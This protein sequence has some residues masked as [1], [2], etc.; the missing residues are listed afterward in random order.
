M[1]WV[2][3]E[4]VPI[5]ST[6][7]L[8]WPK[9]AYLGGPGP[10]DDPQRGVIWTSPGPYLDPRWEVVWVQDGDPPALGDH[11]WK[12]MLTTNPH[13]IWRPNNGPVPNMA[14]L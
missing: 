5:S 3:L 6:C 7:A 12:P 2:D 13:S 11:K 14:P 9:L 4:V 8:K 1:Q 10:S